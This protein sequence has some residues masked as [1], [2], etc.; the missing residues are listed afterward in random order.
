MKQPSVRAHAVTRRSYS[1]PLN[2]EET[3][4]ETWPQICD[5]VIDHQKWLWERAKGEF[6]NAQELEELEELRALLYA[7]KAVL[8]GRTLWLGGT[9]V[10]K[11]REASMFNCAATALRSINDMVDSIWLLLQGCGVGGKMEPGLLSGF[12]NPVEHVEIRSDAVGPTGEDWN[13]ETVEGEV[14][15]IR[16]GDSAEAWAKS[17]GKILAGKRRVRKLV[18]DYR[19]IRP[20]GYRLK[21]YGWISSG[22]EQ[23]AKAIKAIVK[24]MNGAA[25]RLLSKAEIHDIFNWMGT[26]L[27]SRRSAEIAL[28]DFNTEGWEEFTT[29]KKDYWREN[30]QREQSNNSLLF[31][32]KP[33]KLELR[34][35]FQMM[36]QAGGSEPGFINAEHAKR[37]APWFYAGNP[38]FE[39]LLPD[40]GFCNLVETNLAAFNGDYMGLLDALH[41][42]ARANYR[43][44]AVNLRDGILQD[45]WHENNEFLRLCGVGLT[46]IVLWEYKDRVH[47]VCAIKDAA[48][49]GANSMA[50]DLK[51]T[52]PKLV[53]TIKPSGCRPWDAL[54]T[55]TGGIL[56]LEELFG[57]HEDDQEWSDYKGTARVIHDDATRAI[58]KTYVNGEAPVF[59]I[60]TDRYGIELESTADHPW[61]INGIGWRKTI[62]LEPGDQL[63]IELGLYQNEEHAKLKRVGSTAIKMRG[64]ATVVR[65]PDEMNP[66]LSWL[67]GYLWGDGAMSPSRYRL[68][69]T[70]EHLVHLHKATRILREQFGVEASLSDKHKSK[71]KELCV[72][73]KHLW[74]W[75]LLNDVWK[76]DNGGMDTIPAVVRS[77]S[78]EDILAFI[79]GFIDADGNVSLTSGGRKQI[80]LSQADKRFSNHLQH[81]AMAVGVLFGRSH[82]TK[83]VSFQG[84]KS[85]QLLT[86]AAH[87][88]PEAGKILHRHSEKMKRLDK[89]GGYWIW[90]NANRKFKLGT[91]AS[92]EMIGTEPT[93]DIEVEGEHWYYAGGVKSHNT[94][95]KCMD[96]TEG[97]H[98]PLGRYIFNEVTFGKAD[99]LVPKLKEAGY[100]VREKPGSSDSFLVCLPFDWGPLDI[101]TK[102]RVLRKGHDGSEAEVEVEVNLESAVSQLQR[103]KFWMRNY[104]QHNA[105]V[106]ISYDPSEV[107]EI[108]EWLFKNWDNYVGVSWLF[109]NDPTKTCYD[110][111]YP[112]LPQTVVTAA[113]YHEYVT[114]LKPVDFGTAGS[115][116]TPLDDECAGGVCP[117]R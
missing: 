33:S 97:L 19:P 101:F 25:N 64:D 10:S 106:T 114:R 102:K 79:A 48:I 1:R 96:T 18:T 27:S 104:V 65:Q 71:A 57:D 14:W 7:R 49:D 86:V 83:G 36:I 23:L 22:D 17:F 21:G 94:L 55:T 32:H 38:C 72:S 84:E 44:T 110:L 11:A 46:G 111:G 47:E 100:R 77:S 42:I 12:S 95:S 89:R 6:L 20:G 99:P 73:S 60:K 113:E 70:D 13:T 8:S 68:R 78:T 87:T 61:W 67:L 26:V 74:H 80:I 109:R 31:W 24:I 58:T 93:Y 81:V 98:A 28:C 107:D 15:T 116:E 92:V 63:H 115:M 108:V 30:I 117:V 85:M 39:I 90:E 91:V 88:L 43:Q 40:G 82:N 103:Y 37:R 105:S 29:F 3:V 5:R 59:R 56:T 45:K 4:F 41:L 34:G 54:T 2:D 76:Y 9:D 69:W 50:D 51:M 66:D 53:T 35:L 112:Y 62:E 75:L 16:I 52:R